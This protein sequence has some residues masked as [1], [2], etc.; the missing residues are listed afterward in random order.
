MGLLTSRMLSRHQFPASSL[1]CR[2]FRRPRVALARSGIGSV[3]FRDA[4]KTDCP[5]RN[6][7]SCDTVD[8]GG[9]WTLSRLKPQPSDPFEYLCEQLPWHR[10]LRHLEDDV[11]RMLNNLGADLD[12]L[13]P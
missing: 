6:S 1:L 3:A 11:A 13:V 8:R 9:A 10:D 2:P 5:R 12:E 4:I 7:S